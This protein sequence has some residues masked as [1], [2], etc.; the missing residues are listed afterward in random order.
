M[1]IGGSERSHKE[2]I[3]LKYQHHPI[4]DKGVIS[5]FMLGHT[6]LIFFSSHTRFFFSRRPW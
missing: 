6:Y 1:K 3:I 5:D 4:T 2:M